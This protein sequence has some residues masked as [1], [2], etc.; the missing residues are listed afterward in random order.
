MSSKAVYRSASLVGGATLGA[1]LL[2]G[3]A[4]FGDRTPDAEDLRAAWAEQERSGY[5]YAYGEG[6]SRSEAEQVA[7]ERIAQQVSL[8]IRSEY[9]QVYERSQEGGG[10][11]SE[12]SEQ[13]DSQLASLIQADLEGLEP[14]AVEKTQDGFLAVSRIES[15]ALREAQDRSR[16]QAPAL[17]RIAAI[18]QLDS[19]QALSRFQLAQD[20]QLISD[21]RG[22]ADD[23][24]RTDKLGT[25]TFS[26]YFQY[27]AD[28]GQD[29]LQVLPLHS[30]NG[31]E[32]IRLALIDRHSH[33][34][35]ENADLVVNDRTL[36]TDRTGRTQCF[37]IN[38]EAK[39]L[40]VS[41]RG[42]QGEKQWQISE[43]RPREW[44]DT[45][46]A[47][48]YIYVNPKGLPVEVDH[49]RMTAPAKI[50][51]TRAQN[52]SYTL[53]GGEEYASKR[54]RLY[55]PSGA[56][57]V[58]FDETLRPRSFGQLDLEIEGPGRF[59]LEGPENYE[60]G[61][62]RGQFE[63]GN[64]RLFIERSDEDYQIARDAFTLERGGE[65]RRVYDPLPSRNPSWGG[66]AFR[67]DLI[68]A[69]QPQSGLE[70]Q[71]LKEAKDAT[72]GEIR[73]G[74]LADQGIESISSNGMGYGLTFF[75]Q[76]FSDHGL[77]P[78][79]YGAGGGFRTETYTL[80]VGDETIDLEGN[81][82]HLSG[83]VGS[84]I[85][86]R[87]QVVGYGALGATYEMRS[88]ES[89]RSQRDYVRDTSWGTAY[90]YLE[91]GFYWNSVAFSLRAPIS[92]DGV[93][94][95]N[96]GFGVNNFRR[97]YEKEQTRSLRE[98]DGYRV[99]DDKE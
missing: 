93:F 87:D 55:V 73:D 53:S 3:C 84:F 19:E 28:R 96:V 5:H 7:A 50:R 45:R 6:G 14:I 30:C 16:R 69:T 29:R 52:Y 94:A 81:S 48:V 40:G 80:D 85:G 33:A 11:V 9:R 35:Q 77:I 27:V 78:F 61:R 76:N 13:V 79:T 22:V 88:W 46:E 21:Q 68:Q 70:L 42:L 31:S 74:D 15:G 86:I 41:L 1:L 36:S 57:A 17:A 49:T 71:G 18:E 10:G 37:E 98:G 8:V 83:Q 72:Y 64:Y 62:I 51:L 25:T 23:R 59:R 4:S 99:V 32:E 89:K 60:S 47:E 92:D 63:S 44:K 43:L 39:A 90:P 56:V 2:G 75:L 97:G 24:V 65:I 26:E 12:H 38:P 82:Y 67:I 34:P 58:Y 95:L 54:G 20:A 91:A 66:N